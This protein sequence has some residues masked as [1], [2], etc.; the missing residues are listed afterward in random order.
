M[1][2]NKISSSY[3][4]PSSTPSLLTGETHIKLPFNPLFILQKNAVRILT[5]SNYQARFSPLFSSLAILKLFDFVFLDIVLLIYDYYA[6][7]LPITF[8]DFLKI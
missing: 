3:T 7:K 6:H 5:F 4:T 1:L 2:A 8:I